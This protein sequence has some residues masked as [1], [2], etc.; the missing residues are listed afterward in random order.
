MKNKYLQRTLEFH[1]IYQNEILPILSRKQLEK[2]KN[3][4]TPPLCSPPFRD[5][6]VI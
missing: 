3:E 2:T 1:K 5:F 6:C 4:H